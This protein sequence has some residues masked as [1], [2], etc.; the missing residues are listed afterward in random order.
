V[1]K[2]TTASDYAMVVQELYVA[3]FG[4]PADP[5]GLLNFENALLQLK[6]PTNLQ[7][8]I[9]AYS[10]NSGVRSLV[11]SFGLSKESQTLYGTGSNTQFVQAI[12]Y[13]VLGR[14]PATSG[15][16]FW[17][18]AVSSNQVSRGS[19]AL[20]IMAGALA[21][22]SSQGLLDAQLIQNRLQVASYFTSEVSLLGV[23]SR[24]SGATAAASARALLSA[25]QASTPLA[26][27][28]ALTNT[29]IQSL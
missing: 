8:M 28:E 29:T 17:V 11:D 3:Y 2:G 13:N 14:Q 25:V 12:F 27:M 15:L 21:N 16:T 18:G 23:T 5:N 4:R 10:S 19:A 22:Q 9:A 26:S 24:Y 20:Q 6:A 1:S 7:G